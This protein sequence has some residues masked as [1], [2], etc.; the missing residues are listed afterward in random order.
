VFYDGFSMTAQK[1]VADGMR[2]VFLSRGIRSP[3]S[4]EK[5]NMMFS[6]F[7]AAFVTGCGPL[8]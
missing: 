2:F 6:V 7:V 4:P 8:G 1:N 5:K 3:F